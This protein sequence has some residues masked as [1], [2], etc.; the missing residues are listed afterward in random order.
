MSFLNYLFKNNCL[1][2]PLWDECSH[3]GL[4]VGRINL[5]GLFFGHD[6]TDEFEHM[7]PL[8]IKKKKKSS[9]QSSACIKIT[10][11]LIRMRIPEPIPRVG[12]SVGQGVD[13]RKLHF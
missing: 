11:Y 1:Q 3:L 5:E 13:F 6:F 2:S 10:Q 9:C 12:D 4:G 8:L 7:K